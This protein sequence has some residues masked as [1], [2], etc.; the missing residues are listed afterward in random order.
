MAKRFTIEMIMELATR[1]GA[2]PAKA[3][4]RSNVSFLGKGPDKNPLFQRP[5]PGLENA[6]EANLG[7]PETLFTAIEDAVGWM[8]DGK[9]N[10]IQSEILGHN[11]SGIEKVLHPPALPMASVMKFPKQETGI[12]SVLPKQGKVEEVFFD[13]P[14]DPRLYKSSID[15]LMKEG[16]T[17]ARGRRWDFKTPETGPQRYNRLTG[18]GEQGPGAFTQALNQKTG[19]SRAIA[20]QILQQDTRLKLKPEE[21]F[22]LRTGKGEPLDL[23]KKYY[24]KSMLNLDEFL[25][26]VNLQAGN[27]RDL[28]TRVLAEVE[29]IPQFASGGLARM[30]E[31]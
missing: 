31:V 21:L 2:N 7:K 20:R 16:M 29:L 26:N 8:K 14:N 28:A 3:I 25:N 11:L 15:K 27:P 9:L 1:I 18:A 12:A 30:L 5:L 17:D 23:M 24:G 6:T 13:H 4:S 19:M 22:M 10:S